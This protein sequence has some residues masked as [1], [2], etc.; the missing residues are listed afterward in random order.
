[1]NE[2]HFFSVL[3]LAAALAAAARADEHGGFKS[4]FDGKSLAGWDGNEKFWSVKDGTI[5]GQTTADNPTKGNTF[6]I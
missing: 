5:T 2:R 1:M 6:L 3:A 4:L